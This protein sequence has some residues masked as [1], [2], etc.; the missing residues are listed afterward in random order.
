MKTLTKNARLMNAAP[1]MHDALIKT[2]ELL[3]DG[4]AEPYQADKLETLIS[5]ILV[6]LEGPI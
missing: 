2:L 5:E 4:D 3:R 6:N 1:S